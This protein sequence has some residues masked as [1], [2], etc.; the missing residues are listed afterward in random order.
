V[1]QI[2]LQRGQSAL[3]GGSSRRTSGDT[4]AIDSGNVVN[5][6]AIAPQFQDY[7]SGLASFVAAHSV[8]SKSR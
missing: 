8:R 2:V 3:S 1:V 5:A 4:A 6:I 7:A